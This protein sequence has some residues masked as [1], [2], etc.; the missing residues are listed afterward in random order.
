VGSP[1]TGMGTIMST[2]QVVFA[3]LLAVL[4]F[5]ATR[6]YEAYGLEFAAWLCYGWVDFTTRWLPA[7][8]RD[9]RREKLY[10]H[11]FERSGI[12]RGPGDY[13]PPVLTEPRQVLATRLLVDR[14]RGV[15]GDLGEGGQAMSAHIIAA[16]AG[17]LVSLVHRLRPRPRTQFLRP[18]PA[19]MQLRVMSASMRV[20]IVAPTAQATGTKRS[21]TRALGSIGARGQVTAVAAHGPTD[22]PSSR[23]PTPPEAPGCV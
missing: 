11:I 3:V 2:E 19:Q 10:A 22:P 8:M 16:V 9:A 7:D 21:Q 17:R 18:E 4:V 15:L 13:A 6:L 1:G 14:S 5:V 20:S 12:Q 23:A